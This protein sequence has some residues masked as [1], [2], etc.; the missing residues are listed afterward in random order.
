M[1]TN[2]PCRCTRSAAD[3][4][5]FD[6]AETPLQ[7]SAAPL[8]GWRHRFHL[9][10]PAAGRAKWQRRNRRRRNLRNSTPHG[11]RRPWTADAAAAWNA[12]RSSRVLQF[13]IEFQQLVIIP[14]A[15]TDGHELLRARWKRNSAALQAVAPAAGHYGDAP[16]P[17]PRARRP[18]RPPV[19]RIIEANRNR[20]ARAS[21]RQRRWSCSW[22]ASRTKCSSH[23]NQAPAMAAPAGKSTAAAGAPNRASEP[24]SV[25]P[26]QMANAPW[27]LG[28]GSCGEMSTTGFRFRLDDPPG[29]PG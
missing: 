12:P 8:A 7:P 11:R 18:V 13:G 2:T 29:R 6:P 5:G 21:R 10:S 20:P 28:R 16:V 25:S 4:A 15:G 24:L 17:A 9:R 3:M 23:A 14:G 1:V 26:A 19:R 22:P 27:Q